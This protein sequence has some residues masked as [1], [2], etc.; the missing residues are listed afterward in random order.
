[1]VVINA[2]SLSWARPV[3][4]IGSD[5][6]DVTPWDRDLARRFAFRE[7]VDGPVLA[8]LQSYRLSR[9]ASEDSRQ[10]AG[11]TIVSDQD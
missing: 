9:S 11:S 10:V 1:M 6:I 7:I 5:A 4:R 8:D 3:G 2:F